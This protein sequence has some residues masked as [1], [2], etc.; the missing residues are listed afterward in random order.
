MLTRS[1]AALTLLASSLGCGKTTS[2]NNQPAASAKPAEA[3]PPQKPA[4]AAPL[5]KPAGFDAKG[6][7]ASGKTVEFRS[8]IA[9]Q[10]TN[11]SVLRVQLSTEKRTCA[12]LTTKEDPT[13]AEGETL[14]EIAVPKVVKADGE[15]AWTVMQAF[16]FQKEGTQ[17]GAVGKYAAAR[18][19][20]EDPTKEVRVT[21]LRWSNDAVD[22]KVEGTV[23]A[24]GCGVVPGPDDR[25]GVVPPPR[26]Q[27]GLAF[28][29]AGKKLEVKG[30]I[31]RTRNDE[32]IFSTQ[33][34]D[35]SGSSS[36]E[37]QV[38]LLLKNDGT[39][40]RLSGF[41]VEGVDTDEVSR[42]AKVKLGKKAGET[43]A[44]NLDGSFQLGPYAVNLKGKAS[45]LACD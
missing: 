33:P 38:N 23:V 8:A 7:L 14:V 22:V 1:L 40:A 32:L 42:P 15:T 24:E 43:V 35:C 10:Y 9:F 2:T 44:A 39:R 3:A 29:V 27:T 4:E 17:S 19:V 11:S 45:L 36:W 37:E 12:G 16:Y 20:G 6:T 31:Y 18:V 28:E 30:A 13:L 21:L 5:Q 26:P 25:P 41:L 34:L